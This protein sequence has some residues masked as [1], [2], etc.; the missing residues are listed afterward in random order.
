MKPAY[1]SVIKKTPNG[2]N[3]NA[4]MSVLDAILLQHDS[5]RRRDMMCVDDDVK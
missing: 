5:L 4:G 1:G 3:G 2:I